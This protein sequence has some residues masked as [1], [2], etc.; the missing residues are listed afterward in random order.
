MDGQDMGKL[1]DQRGG[2]RLGKNCAFFRIIHAE[3]MRVFVALPPL[4]G[5]SND[6]G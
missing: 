3:I 2:G 5:N 1:I 4:T 6:P